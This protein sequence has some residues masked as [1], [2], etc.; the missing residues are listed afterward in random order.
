MSKEQLYLK[1]LQDVS[2][3]LNAAVEQYDKNKDA[4]QLRT[5]IVTILKGEKK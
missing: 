5:A 4:E 1:V 3:R 2:A